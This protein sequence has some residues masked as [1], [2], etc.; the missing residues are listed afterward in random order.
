MK[1]RSS[2]VGKGTGRRRGREVVCPQL[3]ARQSEPVD[4]HELPHPRPRGIVE[5]HQI[6]AVCQVPR[7]FLPWILRATIRL[8]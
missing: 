5:A 4:V 3:D 8:V 1:E 2:V 6:A 7:E